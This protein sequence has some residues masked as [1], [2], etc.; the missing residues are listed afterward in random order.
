MGINPLSG[1]IPV[2]LQMPV[3]L[4]MFN[5]FPNA[6]ELRQKSFLWATDLSTYDSVIN[7]SFHIPFY[8]NHISLFTLFSTH[9]ILL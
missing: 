5:F 3:L 8:G 6:I 9:L 7:L 4:A 1:C 2:L